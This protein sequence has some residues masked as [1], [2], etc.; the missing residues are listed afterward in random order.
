MAEA[1]APALSGARA[2]LQRAG[3]FFA[4][5]RHLIAVRDGVVGALPLVLVGSLFLLVAQPPL[6]ALQALV[7]PYVPA[8]LVPYRMLGGLIAVY[9]TFCTAHSLAKRYELDPMATGLLAMA[10]YFIAAFPAPGLAGAGLEPAPPWLADA[11]VPR[12]LGSA[13]A[14]AAPALPV[15]RLGA[16]GIFAGLAIAIATAEVTRFFVKRN[17]TIRLPPSA[18]AVVVRS[19]VALVPSL[20]VIAVAFGVTQVARVDVIR[21]LEAAAKPLLV[22][23]GSP[24]A[25]V[26]VVLT[27]SGLWVLGVHA[28]AALATLKPLW[29]TMLVQNME[30]AVAGVRP[31]P[32]IATLPFYQWWVWQGGSGA[33]LP[34][35]LLL[36]RARSA[37]L[38]G[39]GRIAILPAVCNINEPI[40][41]GAPVVMNGALAVPFFAAPI[42]S[43]GVSYLA[44]HLGWVT[45]AYLEMP[46]TLPAPVGAFLAT[47]GDWRA[48]ALQAA[49]LGMGLAIYW[50][51][52][53]RYDARLLAREAAPGGAGA[54]GP[55]PSRVPANPIP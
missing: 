8:L 51:F 31:L 54:P 11:L 39:V 45:P 25:A 40:L 16:G 21:L 41:F 42:L 36:L 27:D 33:S 52:V 50:P 30:A 18:P 53:R 26:A 48:I 29:E 55:T 4:T 35:A 5:Q 23:G 46:W 43:V 2:R 7:A 15:A 44:F 28:G 17:W 24:L 22:A 13:P 12:S 14:A 3:D 9:V 49:N 1:S 37:Q 6:P 47:G 19:F 20:A 38:K 32:H 34:L 10:A